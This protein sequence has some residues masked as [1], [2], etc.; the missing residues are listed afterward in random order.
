M[1]NF[2]LVDDTEYS[3]DVDETFEDVT[4]I[5]IKVVSKE[6]EVLD[7]R[8][9]NTWVP[10]CGHNKRGGGKC[11]A[12]MMKNGKGCK[13]HGGRAKM[14]ME[15]PQTTTGRYSAAMKNSNLGE[16]VARMREDRF[17]L[18]NNEEIFVVEAILEG[19]LE[20]MDRDDIKSTKTIRKLYD[21]VTMAFTEGEVKKA[22]LLFQRLGDAIS[23]VEAEFAL[24]EEIRAQIKLKKDLSEAQTKRDKDLDQMMKA[25]DVQMLL[26]TLMSE[27]RSVVFDRI[28][29]ENAARD[30]LNEVS[31]KLNRHRLG[32]S[33]GGTHEAL[34]ESSV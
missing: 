10:K 11:G 19:L 33:V 18:D 32:L 24:M 23:S 26:A 5:G 12:V 22:N 9:L 4:E 20:R 13:N 21:D 3:V 25:A 2:P 27:F 28:G 34:S 31:E 16:K 17:Y 1:I 14:G 29:D 6:R 7:K 8:N 15:L 30:L